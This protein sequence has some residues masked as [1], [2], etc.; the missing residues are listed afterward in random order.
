MIPAVLVLA[1][2]NR[3]GSFGRGV[4]GERKGSAM[5]HLREMLRFIFPGRTR[6]GP[7]PHSWPV[8]HMRRLSN[9]PEFAAQPEQTDW[10][11]A[12]F[13]GGCLHQANCVKSKSLYFQYSCFVSIQGEFDALFFPS[14]LGQRVL[15][16]QTCTFHYH[17][18]L[19]VGADNR[20]FI[21]KPSLS[22]L[23]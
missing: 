17:F 14:L 19:V 23:S 13:C 7:E 22:S 1:L 6:A 5:E 12:C 4:R 11:A 10:K 8:I 9:W 2:N 18:S 15:A 3:I 16:S 21:L 20:V